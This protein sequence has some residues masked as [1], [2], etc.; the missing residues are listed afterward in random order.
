MRE[1]SNALDQWLLK[2]IVEWECAVGEAVEASQAR[3]YIPT[4]A[5][6]DRRLIGEPVEFNNT[7]TGCHETLARYEPSSPLLQFMDYDVGGEILDTCVDYKDKIAWRL[8]DHHFGHARLY[9]RVGGGGGTRDVVLQFIRIN[10]LHGGNWQQ[11]GDISWRDVFSAE[12]AD[13][14]QASVLER[15]ADLSDV[16]I[17]NFGLHYKESPEALSNYQHTLELTLTTLTRA[18]AA[19]SPS[20]LKRL[21]WCET[22]PQHFWT[23]DGTGDF[24]AANEEVLLAQ[25]LNMSRAIHAG[26]DLNGTIPVNRTMA[27]FEQALKRHDTL[28]AQD[29]SRVHKE[30]LYMYGCAH[31]FKGSITPR[32]RLAADVLRR[33]S[34]IAQHREAAVRVMAVRELLLPHCDLK[35]GYKRDRTD[36]THYKNLDETPEMRWLFRIFSDALHDDVLSK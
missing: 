4:A 12:Q 24:H 2:G 26:H 1:V 34:D 22:R 30:Y 23:G 36:C 32:D 11:L 18:A 15:I 7:G 20:R 28:N 16:M 27:A 31:D 33:Y 8:G 19:D 5:P 10:S 17:V 13:K 6:K 35:V 29:P 14:C 9:K 3:T 25:L 21:G